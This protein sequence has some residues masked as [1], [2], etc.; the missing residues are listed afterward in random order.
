MEINPTLV[1]SVQFANLFIQYFMDGKDLFINSSALMKSMID[2]PQNVLNRLKTHENHTLK[3][4][5]RGGGVSIFTRTDLLDKEFMRMELNENGKT[6]YL[7]LIK[8]GGF[9]KLKL[10]IFE[11]EGIEVETFETLL[12]KIDFLNLYAQ[13]LET[14]KARQ[15]KEIEVL[16]TQKI[17]NEVAFKQEISELEAELD[18]TKSNAVIEKN[19]VV[20]GII[21]IKDNEIKNLITEKDK[22]IGQK[23]IVIETITNERD[24]IL[25]RLSERSNLRKIWLDR[26]A[27]LYAQMLL[28][29]VCMAFMYPLISKHF[30]FVSLPNVLGITF[31]IMLTCM[32]PIASILFSLR[33]KKYWLWGI[34]AF[35]VLF[36]N[37]QTT[38]FNGFLS[39]LNLDIHFIENGVVTF[40]LPLLLIAF[41]NLTAE[42]ETN[43]ALL[44]KAKE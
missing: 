19:N 43:K 9:E 16:Q 37:S 6:E 36:S 11:K 41:G 10:S 3:N 31:Q 2:N 4:S 38:F 13:Q 17:T 44:V 29:S 42:R 20:D 5:G 14:E 18:T 8:N 23:D 28:Q 39:S 34:F 25:E 26:D 35:E 24:E 15:L 22:V 1:K 27:S 7:E 21:A 32:L 30:P 40:F 12:E 33:Q